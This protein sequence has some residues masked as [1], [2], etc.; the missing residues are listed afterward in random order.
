MSRTMTVTSDA[1][2]C[3]GQPWRAARWLAVFM[4]AGF[5]LAGVGAVPT[6]HAEELVCEG[7][8]VKGVFVVVQSLRS[9]NGLVTVELYNDDPEGFIKKAGRLERRRVAASDGYTEV[10]FNVPKPGTYA[11]A[12]YHDEN[13]NKKFDKNFFGLPTEGFGFSNNPGILFGPPD[14]DEA[15]FEVGDTPVTV[16]IDV[17]Y[18]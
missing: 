12:I 18:L 5:A 3:Q 4:V 11:V 15:A 1:R 7:E 13:G 2:G 17:T 8:G 16:H 6:S 14:H 9:A 10:C